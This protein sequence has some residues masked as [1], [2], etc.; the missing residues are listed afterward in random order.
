MKDKPWY[1][2]LY[3]FI[4]T[5]AF[6]SVVIGVGAVTHDR[7]LANERLAFEKSVVYAL[8]LAPG[9]R[10]G[11]SEIHE[12]FARRVKEPT[13]ATA[14]A[15]YIEEG[16]QIAAYAIPIEGRGF[17]DQ[18]K[19][20]VGVGADMRT[21]TGIYFYQ[22]HETPGLGAEITR[23]EFR[24]QFTGL[25]LSTIGKAVNIRRPGTTLGPGEVHAVTGATQTSTRLE[26]LM[27][28]DLEDWQQRMGVR[29]GEQ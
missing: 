18:I 27:N 11:N 20:V 1:P 3:M 25:R 5:A 8:A 10:L 2:V 9:R 6:S 24:D 22:Q 17:W 29:G 15:Y 7:V 12:M 21:V 13:N 16:G 26:L 19:G 23:H 28:E 4:V 14:G